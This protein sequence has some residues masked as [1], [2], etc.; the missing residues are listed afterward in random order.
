MTLATRIKPGTTV[1]LD[2]IDPDDT[3]GLGK[4]DPAVE[5]RLQKHLARIVELQERLFAERRRSLLF[6]IQAMDT[7]GK[8]GTI[9]K[10][11]GPLDSRGCRVARFQAPSAEEAAHDFLWRV[12]A[13]APERG[14]IVVFNR[15]HYEEVLVA[16]VLS[17]A[18][19][20]RWKKR[21]DHIVA[22]ERMLVDE[23]TK[24]VKVYLH[25]SKAEQKK[26]LMARLENPEKRWK[27]DASD[28]PMREK[29]DDFRE[30]YDEAL[31]RCSTEEAPWYVVPA[32]AKWFRNL[33]VAEL[34]ERSLAEL[35][36]RFPKPTFDPA[37]I[38]VK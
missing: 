25:I 36:P 26:R 32:N 11:F 28:L 10:V 4:D 5:K 12:H 30:A 27:F 7:A 35:D 38:V 34:L 13:K 31:T 20:A 16:R 1:S 21:Y 29:W 33:A 14:E 8:D 18:P 19:K 9:R 3:A 2:D 22:F 24:I 15:S 6:V 37:K 17:L 23:G